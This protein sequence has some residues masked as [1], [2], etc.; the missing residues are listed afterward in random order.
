MIK[1]LNLRLMRSL[2]ALRQHP[3]VSVEFTSFVRMVSTALLGNG[4]FHRFRSWKDVPPEYFAGKD[5]CRFCTSFAVASQ[6]A[7]NHLKAERLFFS[8]SRSMP[9]ANAEGPCRSEA[10]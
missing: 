5:S 7:E 3:K 10:T 4:L 2:E 1:V 9:T 6:F 8:I